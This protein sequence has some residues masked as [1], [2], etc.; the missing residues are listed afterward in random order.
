MHASSV[1][2]PGSPNNP[3]RWLWEAHFPDENPRVRGGSSSRPKGLRAG[4]ALASRVTR[5]SPTGAT[6]GIRTRP[7]RPVSIT[8]HYIVCGDVF[9]SLASLV[10]T[11]PAG[12][13]VLS[14][15]ALL[16]GNLASSSVIIKGRWIFKSSRLL[17]D[18]VASVEAGWRV[19][20]SQGF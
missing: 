16:L 3:V 13:S 10:P 17:A 11:S 6:F 8:S 2:S 18:T 12:P 1:Q 4:P 9:S 7:I 19:S 15:V 20:R 14:S 5:G